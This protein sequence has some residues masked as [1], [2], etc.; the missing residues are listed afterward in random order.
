MT[1]PDILKELE[2]LMVLPA[3]TL[4][5]GESLESLG[6]DSI[7]VMGYIAFLGSTLK[8]RVSGKD[9]TS[10]KTVAD[11]VALAGVVD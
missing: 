3:G 8:K 9:V 4:A 11:L 6:W 7:S 1:K 5:G 10:C 2:N